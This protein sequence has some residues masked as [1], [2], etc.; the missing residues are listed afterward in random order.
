[1][2]MTNHLLNRRKVAELAAPGP[3]LVNAIYRQIQT[4]EEAGLFDLAGAAAIEGQTGRAGGRHYPPQA[5]YWCALWHDLTAAGQ[6]AFEIRDLLRGWEAS[7]GDRDKG[8]L[9]YALERDLWSVVSLKYI[10]AEG[11]G[12]R[13]N[14]VLTDDLL[15][16]MPAICQRQP[17]TTTMLLFHLSGIFARVRAKLEAL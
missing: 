4:W 5:A 2:A 17:G 15:G 12:Q 3:I 6:T 16:D 11:L 10:P 14:S 1:M 13:I 9:A 7:P 8:L